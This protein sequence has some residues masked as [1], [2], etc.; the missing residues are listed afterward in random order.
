MALAN[1]GQEL[2]NPVPGRG[3]RANLAAG[4]RLALAALESSGKRS[5]IER[6]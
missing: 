4:N 5:P 2:G 6:N 1:P 3:Y